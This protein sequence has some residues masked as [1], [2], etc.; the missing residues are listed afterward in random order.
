MECRDVRNLLDSFIGQELMIETN[1]E[2]IRHLESCPE[3]RSELDARRQLRTVLRRAFASSSALAPTPG[4]TAD[5][6]ARVREGRPSR[7]AW[8]RVSSLST[9]SKWG[10]LAASVLL[11]AGAG[12]WLSTSRVARI[13]Q[14]AVGDH[15]NCA[16][17]FALTERPIPLSDAAAKYDPVYARLEDTPPDQFLTP[18]GALQVVDRHSCVFAGRRFGHVVLRLDGRLVSVLVT[19][20]GQP[21]ADRSGSA[22]ATPTELPDVDGQHLASFGTPGH[23]VFLVS[24]LPDAQFRT[25]ARAL[26]PALTSR[27]ARLWKTVTVLGD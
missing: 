5:V 16:I 21:A 22:P 15:R 4:F 3:C 13:A 20:D 12:L 11:A 14:D 10:A 25:V 6:L 8:A 1:H 19:R 18:A 7:S 2:L 27:L 9:F 17:K 23:T 24:D 26:T